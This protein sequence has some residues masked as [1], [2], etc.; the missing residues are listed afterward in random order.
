MFRLGKYV[1]VAILVLVPATALAA[2]SATLPGAWQQLRPA[3]FAVPQET[4]SA[5]TGKQL[6]VFGRRPATN[7]STDVAEAYDPAR[8]TWT[9]LTPPAGP[10]MSPGYKA[11]WTG[12]EILAFGA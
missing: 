8:D 12:K 2:G 9:R 10:H 3:P 4:A 7:P 5:W 1:L 11:V 6:I